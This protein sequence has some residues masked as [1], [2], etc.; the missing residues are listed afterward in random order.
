MSEKVNSSLSKSRKTTIFPLPSA[1]PYLFEK[2]ERIREHHRVLVNIRD[3][4]ISKL[5]ELLKN[6]CPKCT[7][8][9][10]RGPLASEPLSNQF[11]NYSN[12]YFDQANIPVEDYLQYID[13]FD[14]MIFLY[15]PSINSS[16]RLLDAIVRRIPVCL[17][18]ESTEWCD[19]AREWGELHEYGWL[20]EAELSQNFNHPLFRSPTNK[21]VPSFTPSGSRFELSKFADFWKSSKISSG[22]FFKL[23]TFALILVHWFTSMLMNYLLAVTSRVTSV[24]LKIK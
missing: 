16:G 17:P 2:N 23:V 14:Y 20:N 8:V 24:R 22:H 15:S 10:P 4:E 13:Q 1:L 18:R 19:I 6:S 21:R 12:L 11:G 9:L 3:F 5:H 7:F